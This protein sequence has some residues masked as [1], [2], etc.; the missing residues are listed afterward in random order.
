[1]QANI[2]Y[3]QASN[4][5]TADPFFQKIIDQIFP[6]QQL[7]WVKQYLHDLGELC[8]KEIDPLVLA[9]DHNPPV[10]V[11][12]NP[13]GQRID[14]VQY[15]WS[16]QKIA[17][18]IY[19]FGILGLGNSTVFQTH[20]PTYN[21]LLK[22]SLGYV[23]SQ[24]VS[25]MYCPICMTDG[26]FEI[27]S[28]YGSESLKAQWLPRLHALDYTQFSSSGM[29]LTE[30]QGGS[31]V[32][33]NVCLAYQEN[34]EWKLKGE[35]WFCSNVG[36]D[37]ALALAR[38]A[39][40]QPG[41]AGLSLFLIPRK[42][43]NSE[44]NHIEIRRLKNKLGTREMATGEI[45]FKGALAYLIGDLAS[46]FKY[47]TEMLNL[48]RIYNTVWS[49][50]LIRRAYVEAEFYARHR[51]AFGQAII[52]Y[53]L[54]AQ[55]LANMR[56]T[57]EKMT[58][59]VFEC[60]SYYQQSI[61]STSS[62]DVAY[63][64]SQIIRLLIPVMKFYTAQQAIA[65]AHQAIEILGGNGC[66]ENFRV[67]KILRDSQI[68]AVWEGTANILALDL[69]RVL[70]KTDAHHSFLASCEQQI[71]AQISDPQQAQYFKKQLKTL[72]SQ[73]QSVLKGQDGHEGQLECRDLAVNIAQFHSTLVWERFG[74]KA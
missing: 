26:T 14:Q 74:S 43:E 12:Y 54:V 9:S 13:L 47:M 1:M 48:S 69:L 19:E 4:F 57:S 58:A 53:P 7:T 55:T 8:A 65:C 29:Y 42:L 67:A 11:Q 49:I 50:G 10:L 21:P 37:V 32:G 2:P 73:F 66:I 51:L 62:S 3:Y 17:R 36:S 31:D 35:K 25:V 20:H 6:Q 15:H 44:H 46:G 41:T 39:K 40:S 34:N 63:N 56:E 61:E 16:Y 72:K 28:K 5:Y 23:F 30:A 52:N 59:W 70:R 33:A 64:K 71:N 18:L 45:S 38:T 24:T 27:V 60:I 68:L 22:F